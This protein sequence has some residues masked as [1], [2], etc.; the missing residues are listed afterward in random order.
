MRPGREPGRPGLLPLCF[1]EFSF[2]SDRDVLT[3][4]NAAGLEGSI[5][6]QAEILSMIFA[7]AEIATRKLPHGSLVGGVGPS[8]SKRT[9]RVTPWMVRSPSTD[10]SSSPTILMPVD[11]KSRV[12]NFSTSKKSALLRC[13]SRWLSRVSIEAASIEASTREFARFD[14]SKVNTPEMFEKWPLTHF[15][16]LHRQLVGQWTAEVKYAGEAGLPV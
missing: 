12:R 3:D 10:S 14:L 15:W 9:L 5:P 4:K 13:A 7:L 2:Q 16:Q 8:T 1:Y 6:G 11:L